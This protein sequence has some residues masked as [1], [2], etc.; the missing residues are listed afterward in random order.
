MRNVVVADRLFLACSDSK[1]RPDMEMPVNGCFIRRFLPINNPGTANKRAID[2]PIPVNSS[3][4]L[5]ALVVNLVVATDDTDDCCRAFFSGG[6][7]GLALTTA[8]GVGTDVGTIVGVGV[9]GEGG[10]D[11]R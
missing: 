6:T 7:F 1:V 4:V 10:A 9:G 2:N 5:V 8:V 3:C 11:A